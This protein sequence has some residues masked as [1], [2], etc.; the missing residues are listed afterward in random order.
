MPAKTVVVPQ[1][2]APGQ[3]MFTNNCKHSCYLLRARMGP[4]RYCG[5]GPDWVLYSRSW[6]VGLSRQ[7]NSNCPYVCYLLNYYLS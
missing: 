3:R 5:A 7:S 4:E 6:D 2:N 1:Y